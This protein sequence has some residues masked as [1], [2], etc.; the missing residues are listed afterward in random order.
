[1]I[2]EP[3]KLYRIDKWFW[4][5]FPS[6]ETAT[7]DHHA[8]SAVAAAASSHLSKQLN[9][10][11]SFLNEKDTIMAVEVSGEQIKVINQEGK[12]GWINF[13]LDEVWVRKA[14][15]KVPDDT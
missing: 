13:P 3:G 7:A 9:C 10:N 1:M 11:V 6:L 12:S 2:F 4:F 8:Y 5:L 14:I 15:S